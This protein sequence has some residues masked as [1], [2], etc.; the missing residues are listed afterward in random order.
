M[1]QEQEKQLLQAIYDRLFDAITYQPTGGVNPF[2]ESETFVHF[3]KNAALEP[4]EYA[5]P[6]TPS[7]PTGNMRS[8]EAFSRMVDYVS[9]MEI[10]WNPTGSSLS[11]TFKLIVDSA[12]ANV[13]DDP[14]AKEIYD[15]AYNYL[16]PETTTVNP[17]TGESV[18]ERTDSADYVAYEENMEAYV[19]AITTYRL[20]Y[21]IYLDALEDPDPD[22]RK[23]ADRDWQAKAPLLENSIKSAFRKLQSGNAKYVEQ[24]LMILATTVN[25]GIRRAI[26]MAQEGVAD[27]RAFSSSMGMPDKWYLSYPVP[28]NWTDE[29]QKSFTE[30]HI[31]GG[32][33]DIRNK[34]TEHNFNMDTSLNYGLWK[35]KANAEGKYEH[36]NSSTAKD[37]VEISAKICKVTVMRPWFTDSLFRLAKWTTDLCGNGGISNGKIDSSNRGNLLP[38]YPVAFVVA[39]DISIKADFTKEDRDIIEES[40]KTGV[41][42]GWG[43]FAIGGSYGYGN[44]E[45]TFHSEFQ[46]GELK[47]PGMQI[48]AW[49]SRVVPFSTK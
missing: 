48:I 39:K 34:S 21:N 28:G 1:T 4:S 33:T 6:V 40:Y 12:N 30:L 36:R 13:E 42:V 10:E 22:V 43:P 20:S 32:Q 41:S 29:S 49:I 14:K 35:V 45:D 11:S 3:S 31:S 19:G 44:S 17:F 25:D 46:N 26:V 24:A 15:K 2:T 5:D 37:S 18:T 27:D 23:K 9:P 47:V 16:H 38:M 8:S 7:N